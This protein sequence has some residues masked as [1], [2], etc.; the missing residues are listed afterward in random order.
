MRIHVLVEGLSEKAFLELWL[1]R[2]LP[3]HAFK[4]IPH[5]GKGKIPGDPT[6]TPDP[7]RQGLLDQLPA[8][9]RAYGRELRSETDRIL[10]LVDLDHDHCYELKNRLVNLLNYCDPPPLALF[11]IA[12]EEFEAFYLGDRTAIRTTFPKSKLSKMDTYVQDSICSTWELFRDVIGATGEDKPAWA[13]LLGPHLTT[14]WKGNISN[15]FQQFCKGLLQLA[16]EVID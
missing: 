5:R 13:R 7:K 11:R 14:K 1:P 15:S 8:K 4:I 2:F 6:Q 3:H 12:I 16:G 10:V 9:L